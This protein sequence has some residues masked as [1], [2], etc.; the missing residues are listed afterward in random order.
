MSIHRFTVCKAVVVSLVAYLLIGCGA[1]R[2]GRESAEVS[3]EEFEAILALIEGIGQPYIEH[4]QKVFELSRT[5]EAEFTDDQIDMLLEIVRQQEFVFII[6]QVDYFGYECTS[7]Y[8]AAIAL[9]ADSEKSRDRY[10]SLLDSDDSEVSA[11][12]AL[13][14]SSEGVSSLCRDAFSPDGIECPSEDLQERARRVLDA[15]K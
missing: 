13:S 3:E 4:S 10:C 9:W 2:E 6:G 14:L 1:G 15:A 11:R 12:I 8:M 5:M 7:S